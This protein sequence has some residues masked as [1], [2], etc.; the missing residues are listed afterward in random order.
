M[1]LFKLLAVFVLS[2]SFEQCLWAGWTRLNSVYG[3][4]GSAPV[5][6]SNMVTIS[7]YSV[8]QTIGSEAVGS[9][10]FNYSGGE[11]T[12]GYLS[13]FYSTRLF[14]EILSFTSDKGM[15]SGGVLWGTG[16]SSAQKV[17][18]SNEMSTSSLSQQVRVTQVSDHLAAAVNSTWTVNVAYLPLESAVSIATGSAVWAK[19]GLFAINFSSA[20]KDLNGLPV[21]SGATVYFSVAMD[22]DQNNVSKLAGD[23]SVRINLSSETFGSD[24]FVVLSTSQDSQAISAANGKNLY[25]FLPLKTLTAASYD[26]SGSTI[27]PLIPWTLRFD[28]KDADNNGIVDGTNP[29]VKVRNLSVWWLNDDVKT[30]V[31]QNG[32]VIDRTARTVSLNTGH[33]STYALMSSP[34]EDVSSVHAYPVPFRPNASGAARSGT[35]A[36]GIR[37]TSPPVRG[38]IKIYT[39]SGRLV[40]EIDIAPATIINGEIPWDV[41]NS[42]GELVASGVYI[43]EV[44]SGSNRKTGKLV[45]IK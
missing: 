34:D 12:T 17:F 14:P 39:I 4:Y 42:D 22:K 32:A 29:K 2:F 23:D 5:T 16:E 30:W 36:D 24:F 44:T 20:L 25:G 15:V 43:W 31:R 35:W 7:S 10:A 37:F 45:I 6:V 21:A 38:K 28:Y 41:K 9:Y 11:L 13:Q 40:K 3:S 33:F 26:V 19:G 27:Q 18:F 8:A 1:N